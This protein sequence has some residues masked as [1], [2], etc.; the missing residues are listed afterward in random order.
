MEPQMH[1][2]FVASHNCRSLPLPPHNVPHPLPFLLSNNP[3]QLMDMLIANLFGMLNIS[4]LL[5]LV[6]T[7]MI[8]AVA[9]RLT[10][11]IT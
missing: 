1:L 10:E 9:E 8:P 4:A 3:A 5:L 6:S 2:Y 7:S 11:L